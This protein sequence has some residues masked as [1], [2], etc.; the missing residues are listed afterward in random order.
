MRQN[1]LAASIQPPN[2]SYVAPSS[3]YRNRN[4]QSFLDLRYNFQN[5]LNVEPRITTFF[6]QLHFRGAELLAGTA[7]PI[8]HTQIL[9]ENPWHRSFHPLSRLTGNIEGLQCLRPVPN[10]PLSSQMQGWDIKKK[11]LQESPTRPIPIMWRS[12]P[13]TH[14]TE[15]TVFTPD[16]K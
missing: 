16:V 8:T 5:T 2:Q 6:S 7:K 11:R 4:S 1:P 9:L 13:A 15:K 12:K 10:P 14:Q 3:N